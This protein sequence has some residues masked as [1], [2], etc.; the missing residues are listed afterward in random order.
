MSYS[1]QFS[2]DAEAVGKKFDEEREQCAGWGMIA[3]ELADIDAAK[4]F[5]VAIATANGLVSGSCSGHWSIFGPDD[6]KNKFGRVAVDVNALT[7][8]TS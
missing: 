6:P 2:G 8:S 5:V 7:T 3:A 1:F 4:E